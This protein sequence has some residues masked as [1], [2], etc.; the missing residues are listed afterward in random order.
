M[1]RLKSSRHSVG[2][3]IVR[4]LF[5]SVCS[6]GIVWLLYIEANKNRP[7]SL[8]VSYR[9]IRMPIE[10]FLNGDYVLIKNLAVKLE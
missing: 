6:L 8:K 10:H 9:M 4:H 1:D 2:V 3:S 5:L 7:L